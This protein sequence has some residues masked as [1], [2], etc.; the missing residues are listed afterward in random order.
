MFDIHFVF[1]EITAF[2][3][4]VLSKMKEQLRE[5]DDLSVQFNCF[6]QQARLC[7]FS[8]ENAYNWDQLV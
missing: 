4:H 1:K 7:A 6:Q 5:G 2:E 3:R 8:D